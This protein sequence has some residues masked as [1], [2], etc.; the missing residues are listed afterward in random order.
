MLSFQRLQVELPRR[1]FEFELASFKFD[2]ELVVQ[3]RQLC[4]NSDIP[5]FFLKV[6]QDFTM[7][8]AW[9]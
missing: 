6:K 1:K 4:K 9:E 8:I 7:L 5:K 2:S 3:S